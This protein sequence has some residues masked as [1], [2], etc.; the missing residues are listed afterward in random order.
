MAVR[1]MRRGATDFVKRLGDEIPGS[2]LERSPPRDISIMVRHTIK[3]SISRGW[4]LA[5]AA[6]CV[7]ALSAAAVCWG[8]VR[9]GGQRA[10]APQVRP[11]V[12]PQYHPPAPG[13]ARPPQM[14]SPMRSQMGPRGGMRSGQEHLPA[15]WAAHRSLPP[16]QQVDALRRQPG[17]RN[18]PPQQQQRLINRLQR[19]DRQPPQEQQRTLDRMESFERLSPERRQE[20]RGAS[21]AFRQ[22]PPDRQ[23][24]MRRAF[25]QLRQMPPEERQRML[26]SSYG[27]QFSPRE[28]TI[29][30]NLLSI[31][32]YQGR[33]VQPY[34]GR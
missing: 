17:F 13:P 2:F 11:Q 20:V 32:P 16:Q 19:F 29:L 33:I 1:E 31:E 23:Q 4:R 7:L 27:A 21:Q 5:R 25:Q 30:G 9:R 24:A 26:D 8:Q 6:V 3:N 12:R 14:R 10:E 18:L 15:W 22:M 28:R 34:F